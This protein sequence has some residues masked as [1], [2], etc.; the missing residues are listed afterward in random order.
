MR[1]SDSRPV[2][3]TEHMAKCCAQQIEDRLHLKC[4]VVKFP[5]G[6]QVTPPHA[7]GQTSSDAVE[8]F[9]VAYEIGWKEC[10]P[11]QPA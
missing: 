10:G 11:S 4:K 8:N 3:R 5:H 7:L 9:I 2:Y 6:W 1:I